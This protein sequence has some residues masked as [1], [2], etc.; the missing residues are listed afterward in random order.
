MSPG[1]CSDKH[2]S[3]TLLEDGTLDAQEKDGY[4]NSFSLGMGRDSVP[5]LAEQE[6]NDIFL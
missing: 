2:I 3:S 5:E 6:E 4:K 1:I